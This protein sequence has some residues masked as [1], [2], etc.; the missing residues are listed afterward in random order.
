[1]SRQEGPQEYRAINDVTV[2]MDQMQEKMSRMEAELESAQRTIR[3]VGKDRE[4]A[5]YERN[6]IKKKLELEQKLVRSLKEQVHAAQHPFRDASPDEAE[7]GSY[8]E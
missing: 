3:Y 5:I 4:Q 1:M 7:E 2:K 8:D 6:Q